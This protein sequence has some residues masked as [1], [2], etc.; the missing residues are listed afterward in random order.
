MTRNVFF[1]SSDTAEN[2]PQV[3][4]YTFGLEVLDSNNAVVTSIALGQEVKLRI[5]QLTGGEKT[6]LIFW[7]TCLKTSVYF[8]RTN[9]R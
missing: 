2:A 1:Y 6:V 7:P 4:M 9:R 5:K 3:D 8:R